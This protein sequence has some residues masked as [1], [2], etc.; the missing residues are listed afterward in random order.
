M[1]NSHSI[2]DDSFFACVT[3][4]VTVR[5]KNASI[6]ARV[7]AKADGIQEWKRI[8]LVNGTGSVAR[9]NG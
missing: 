4:R 3:I 7:E 8:R 9:G 2:R 5:K 1:A 6:V